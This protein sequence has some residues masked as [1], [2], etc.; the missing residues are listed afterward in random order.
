MTQNRYHLELKDLKMTKTKLSTT[1][2]HRDE[3][4][5]VEVSRAV[6]IRKV[7]S[8]AAKAGTIALLPRVADKFL[9][10]PAY[11]QTSGSGIPPLGSNGGSD[12]IT[13]PNF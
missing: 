6:F 13:F 10:P 1:I 7:V 2:A 12:V 5:E 11:A 9:T 3:I 8:C 4:T